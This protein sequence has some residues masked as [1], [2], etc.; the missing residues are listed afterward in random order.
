LVRE[1]L[2]SEESYVSSLELLV[3]HYLVALRKHPDKRATKEIGVIFGNVEQILTLNTD[4]RDQLRKRVE[5]WSDEQLLGDIFLKTAPFFRLYFSYGT[6]YETAINVY[7]REIKE[8]QLFRELIEVNILIVIFF[9]DP[10]LN[11]QIRAKMQKL[12]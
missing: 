5:D 10:N 4:L 12:E 6:N 7:Q 1:I 2:S 3:H 8:N 9:K 11:F